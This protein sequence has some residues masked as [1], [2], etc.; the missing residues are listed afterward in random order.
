MPKA[1]G[2]PAGRGPALRW[3]PSACLPCHPY[4]GPGLAG[5]DCRGAGDSSEMLSLLHPHRPRARVS[6]Y[7]FSRDAAAHIA[8]TTVASDLAN[9]QLP[10]LAIFVCFDTLTLNAYRDALG[11]DA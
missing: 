7:R 5:W 11:K 10:E 3:I 9:Q 4:G 8:V 2:M 6:Q 1:G